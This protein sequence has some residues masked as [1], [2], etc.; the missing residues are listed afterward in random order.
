MKI[1]LGLKGS[2]QRAQID[3]RLR[4]HPDVYEFYTDASDFTPNGYQHLYEAVQ[5]VQ[6]RGVS[7]IVLH[8]PMK[9]GATHTEIVAPEKQF[10]NCIVLLKKPQCS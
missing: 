5:Y 2:S 8:H 4:H 9:F 6:S 3:D 7:R 10:P 1:L